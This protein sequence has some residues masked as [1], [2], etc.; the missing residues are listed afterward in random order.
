MS[1]EYEIR[2]RDPAGVQIAAINRFTILEYTLVENDVGSLFLTRNEGIPY[3]WFQ[4]DVRLEVWRSIDGGS[5]RLE[6][7]TVWF[8]RKP[9]Q[10]TT[11][12]RML[13][14]AAYS[15]K[16]L[17]KRRVIAY[18]SGTAQA[19]KTGAA[20]NIMKA[21]VR[22]NL[23]ASATDTARIMSGL[24]VAADNGLGFSTSKSFSFRNVL[25]VLQELAAD[26]A[27]NGTYLSFDIVRVDDTTLEFRTY[28]NMRGNDHR[29]YVS[30]N[31]VIISPDTGTL[32]NVMMA[33]DATEEVNFAYALGQGEGSARELQSAYNAARVAV[34]PYNR[35]EDAVEASN[36]ALGDTASLL[37]EAKA[38]VRQGRVRTAFTGELREARDLRYGVHFGWGDAITAQVGT[39]SFNCRIDQLR[40]YINVEQGEAVNVSLRND[41]LL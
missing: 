31:P 4:T 12:R 5:E 7:D 40:M 15:A 3:E 26:S 22:E 27:E 32:A 10:Q 39:R 17:L 30:A 36:V 25:T 20:S 18:K 8:V 41:E 35:I 19:T 38:R 9:E 34:S 29:H 11:D 1:A 28:A 2:V 23:G 14:L 21:V 13:Y 37:A 24:Q 6:G 33:D 16:H